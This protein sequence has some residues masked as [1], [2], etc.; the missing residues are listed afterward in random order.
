MKKSRKTKDKTPASTEA[1]TKATIM[2]PLAKLNQS[3]TPQIE[4]GKDSL[5]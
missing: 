5:E 3:K 1:V 4:S 2:K